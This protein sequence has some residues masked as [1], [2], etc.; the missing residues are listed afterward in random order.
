MPSFKTPTEE[1]LSRAVQRMRS[2][3]FAAYF[4]ARLEN[5][6]WIA[7]L[8]EKGLFAN[9]PPAIRDGESV[10]FPHW[11]ASEY[12]M[13]MAA[14]D[15]N[16]VASALAGVVTDN[17]AVAQN[18]VDAAAAMPASHGAKLV[19]AIAR[20]F[21]S[22]P[23]LLGV[24]EAS[25]LCV[26]LAEGGETAAA[27]SLALV[28]FGSRPDR[29]PA[30]RD[31]YWLIRGL[32]R[33]VPAL[34]VR[35][36]AQFLAWL[37][38]WLSAAIDARIHSD[39]ESGRDYSFVWR[40][41]V[42]EHEQNR[43]YEFAGAMVG[44]VRNGFEVALRARVLS[45]DAALDILGRYR[46]LIFA[47]I[48][49]HLV[50]EFADIRPDLARQLIM[51]RELFDDY[52]FKHEYAMLAGRRFD[53][54]TET[55]RA[56]WYSWVDT[57][58]D[59][60][61]FEERWRESL[62]REPTDEDRA[63]RKAYW[64]FERLHW[65]RAH[66]EDSRRAFY[67]SMLARH[68]QPE[69][70]DLNSRISVGWRGHDSPISTEEL[71]A[72]PFEE[73]VV[74]V[75][76]WRPAPNQFEGPDVDGLAVAF[77]QCVERTPEALSA[78]AGVLVGKPPIYVR[79]FIDQMAL[80]IRAGRNIDLPPVL[81]LCRWV[82]AQP[83]YGQSALGGK[84]APGDSDWNSTREAISQLVENACQAK[85]EAGPKYSLHL[86]DQLWTLISVLCRDPAESH[87]VH[88]ASRDDPRIRD[89]LGLAIN[90]PRGKALEA[91]LEYARWV[92]NHIMLTRRQDQ[93]VTGGFDA[94]PE[95]REA[96]DWQISEGNRSFEAMAILGSRIGLI[97]WID[98]QWL[99]QN[100]ERVFDLTGIE[101][102][103]P[104]PHGWAAWN[105]FVVWV[106]PHVEYYR[107]LR[108]QF[109]YAVVQSA[110]V[111]MRVPSDV[112][113]FN[114]LGEHLVILFGRGELGLDDDAAL[115][116][117]FLSSARPEVRRHAMGF[118]GMSLAGEGDIPEDIAARFQKIWE[119]YWDSVGKRDAHEDPETPLFGPWFASERFPLDWALEQLEAFVEVSPT[120]QPDEAVVKRLAVTA[121]T[122]PTR[123]MRILDR[124]VRADHEGWRIHGWRDS[125]RTVLETGMRVGGA[126]RA[127]AIQTI[128]YL[129]RRGYPDFGELL[130]PGDTV[131]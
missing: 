49:I 83:A 84:P 96:L 109:S 107:L 97:C 86:R 16:N 125:A 55:E 121:G 56:D 108:G 10:A 33:V 74:R 122:A 31:A 103:P 82:I 80:A 13:R 63:N 120:P 102:T 78:R 79:A 113:P 46:Y 76:T 4:F 61:R 64:Q 73:V 28:L 15:P 100:A 127:Q 70:A 59:M 114:R 29:K 130:T 14:L 65:V 51:S 71:A 39:R 124:M 101:R 25:N 47:R 21:E 93:G 20:A 12:L 19:P 18:I 92:A 129:G 88:D 52:G 54:L 116:R 34:S 53:Q 75:S 6:F 66:L 77:A 44:F 110:Q 111:P 1:Q 23:V 5:P 3:E 85:W 26:R 50:N 67:D 81:G 131:V 69:L 60:T 104:S 37:C 8:R 94:M 32:D 91:A 99:A 9:P 57:G 90:S 117:R 68:G 98:R 24:L 40:P 41:A 45:P 126:A 112:E 27:M 128:D 48:R 87:I 17:V 62:G 11:P 105:A 2:P 115:L 43:D 35:E 38:D 119:F 72:L 22:S 7:G 58:P 123:A 30:R 118:I 36:P 106:A 89:Y 42:E 95:V